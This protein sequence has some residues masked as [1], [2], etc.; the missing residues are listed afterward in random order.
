MVNC[1]LTGL[2]DAQ[3]FGQTLFW[4]SLWVFLGKIKIWFHRLSKAD[5]TLCD[6]RSSFNQMKVW[7]E[8]KGLLRGNFS[9]LTTY[10]LGIGFFLA[11]GLKLKH[12]L[13]L[14]L[15]PPTFTLGLH[16]QLPWFLGLWTQT[17]T[18]SS[19]PLSPQLAKYGSWDLSG[20][21]V[22]WANI[23]QELSLLI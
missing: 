14:G 10:K 3:T 9:C 8:L 4:V 21:I 19:T 22:V 5:C 20:S 16:H 18:K 23:L 2:Q 13:F 11:F 6:G 7:M 12:Q 17:G 1:K 15:K